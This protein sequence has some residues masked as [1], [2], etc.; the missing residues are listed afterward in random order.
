MKVPAYPTPPLETTGRNGFLLNT[1]FSPA[2]PSL[3]RPSRPRDAPPAPAPPETS[4][5]ALPSPT[6]GPARPRPPASRSPFCTAQPMANATPGATEGSGGGG[7]AQTPAQDAAGSPPP[8][9]GLGAAPL[10][11][12]PGRGRVQGWGAPYAP[13]SLARPPAAFPPQPAPGACSLSAGPTFLWSCHP[14]HEA[15]W[16]GWLRLC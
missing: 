4:A 3:L 10:L 16:G 7:V 14:S 8:P 1:D 11:R 15:S 13:R 5:P 9:A 2:L 6:G 12:C